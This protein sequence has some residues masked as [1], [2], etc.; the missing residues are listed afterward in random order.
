[1]S[2][3]KDEAASNPYGLNSDIGSSSGPTINRLSRPPLPST[4][5]GSFAAASSSAT[6]N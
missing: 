5:A 2:P 3:P 4:K 1:M 6:Q